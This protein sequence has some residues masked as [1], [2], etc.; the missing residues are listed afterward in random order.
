M[1]GGTTSRGDGGDRRRLA[2][3]CDPTPPPVRSSSSSSLFLSSP[4]VVVVVVVL[5]VLF[6]STGQDSLEF[7]IDG[8]FDG[9]NDDWTC[10]VL[11]FLAPPP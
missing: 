10:I 4:L 3:E 11:F 1:E 7:A 8:S 2:I 5:V 9:K 6:S